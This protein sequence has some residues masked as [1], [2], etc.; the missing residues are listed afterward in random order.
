MTQV[1]KQDFANSLSTRTFLQAAS[2]GMD[3]LNTKFSGTSLPVSPDPNQDGADTTN[4]LLCRRNNANTEWLVDGYLN[5]GMLYNENILINGE[6]SVWQRNTSFTFADNSAGYTADMFV[7]GNASGE[8]VTINRENFTVGQTDVPGNPNFFCRIE[9]TG[10][11]GIVDFYSTIENVSKY[12]GKQIT[13]SLY[14]KC[15]SSVSN[16]IKFFTQQVFGS[17][18]SSS[19]YQEGSL[20]SVTTG[21]VRYSATFTMGNCLGKTIGSMDHTRFGFV[22]DESITGNFDCALL[23]VELGNVATEFK[24][25]DFQDTLRKSKRY[26]QKSYTQNIFAGDSVSAGANWVT[27]NSNVLIGLKVNFEVEMHSTPALYIY[28]T[29]GTFDKVLINNSILHSFSVSD[30]CSKS[31]RIYVNSTDITYTEMI[32]HHIAFVSFV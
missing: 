4:N 12:S 24:I 5:K 21:W 29:N 18:G 22:I 8:S 2:D 15:D 31:F 20:I 1:W 28:A 6:L 13:I 16:A 23:K 30:N 11:S 25:N 19:V 10:T 26:Y 32:F 27:T 9:K 7:C 14:L 17:G 3:A